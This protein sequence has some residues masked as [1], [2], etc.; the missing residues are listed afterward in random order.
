MFTGPQPKG[1][2]QKGKLTLD[3]KKKMPKA[4][5]LQIFNVLL[6]GPRA[7][8]TTEPQTSNFKEI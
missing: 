7:L 8:T 1:A 5:K 4:E 6:T 3:I 2:H